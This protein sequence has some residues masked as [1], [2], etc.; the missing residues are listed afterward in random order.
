MR[1]HLKSLKSSKQIP[2]RQQ[3]QQD[4]CTRPPKR[5]VGCLLKVKTV[6]ISVNLVSRR[7]GI[8]ALHTRLERGK[9]S[10]SCLHWER[11]S[12]A[13][14]SMGVGQDPQTEHWAG[15]VSTILDVLP[16]ERDKDDSSS[17]CGICKRI[18]CRSYCFYEVGCPFIKLVFKR[19]GSHLHQLPHPL[20]LFGLFHLP[21]FL[22]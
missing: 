9:P 12:W 8:L 6:R 18:F 13:L 17:A 14:G 3:A 16:R 1:L 5:W 19:Y 15:L 10:Q 7:C 4:H 2:P 21:E 20:I 11:C 22:V